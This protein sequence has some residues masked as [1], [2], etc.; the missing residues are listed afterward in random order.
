MKTRRRVIQGACAVAAAVGGGAAAG[1]IQGADFRNGNSW[2]RLRVVGYQFP[3]AD[4]VDDAN[5]LMING[6]CSLEGRQWAFTDPC[7]ETWDLVELAN[8]LEA[9]AAGQAAPMVLA[10]TEP[11][12]EF[13]VVGGNALRIVFSLESAPGR[14]FRAPESQRRF[15]MPITPDLAVIAESLR[16]QSSRFPPKGK[17]P[18]A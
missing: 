18:G 17:R 7:L 16:D 13:Q 5:W 15:D 12:L 4:N 10:F 6:E 9:L 11:N 1:A 3:D 8:W 2:F 14:D